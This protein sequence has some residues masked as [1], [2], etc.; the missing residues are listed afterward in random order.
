MDD[1]YYTILKISSS[2]TQ[3][4]IK[5]AYRK[6]VQEHHPDVTSS[7]DDE[8][9]KVINVAY[10]TLSD[11]NKKSAY[12][13]SLADNYGTTTPK[14]ST[15]PTRHS[16]RNYYRPPVSYQYQQGSSNYTFSRKTQIIG[17][18]ATVIVLLLVVTAIM[19]MHY[20]ASEYYYDEGIAAE[21]EKNPEKALHFYQLAIRDWGG[22]NIEASIRSAEISKQIGAYYYMVEFCEQGLNN[23]PDTIESARLYYL[24]AYGYSKSQ[25]YVK[26]EKAFLKSLR[27]KFNKDTVYE[28]LGSLYLNRLAKYSEA[29]KIYTHLLSGNSIDLDDYYN[30]A[31]CYQY[32]GKHESAIADLLIVLKDDPYNRATLFQLGRSYLALG[33]KEQACY[34]LRFSK[35][36][37]ANIDPNDLSTAC[38]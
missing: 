27:F 13:R 31:L 24:E 29:E 11:P 10:E 14:Y 18:T 5:I 36:Q 8:F 32:L 21:K 1:N 17:W 6:L 25:R 34:Y 37:G 3:R 16:S 33:N 38:D 30:R 20:F 23:E 35:K 12:D 28:E 22:K 2:A 4:D 7:G 19:G 15:N 9:I 26:A